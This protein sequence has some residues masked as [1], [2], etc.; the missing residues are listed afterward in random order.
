MSARSIKLAKFRRLA[1]KPW[2]AGLLAALMMLMFGLGPY[3]GQAMAGMDHPTKASSVMTDGHDMGAMAD[4]CCDDCEDQNSNRTPCQNTAACM[5]ACGKL[6]LEV[7]VGLN[8]FTP[9]KS[10][11]LAP[12]VSVAGAGRSLSPLRRPPKQV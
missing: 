6:P 10:D 1:R 7:G 4:P 2:A 9:L 5:A 12:M 11:E 3:N 8:F